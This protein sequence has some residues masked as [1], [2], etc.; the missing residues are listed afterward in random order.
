MYTFAD[1]LHFK[2]VPDE[3]FTTYYVVDKDREPM[4]S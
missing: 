3:S 1:Y 4:T 2:Y